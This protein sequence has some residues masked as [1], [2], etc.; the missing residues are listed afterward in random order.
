MFCGLCA[1][2]GLC[3]MPFI[4]GLQEF[5]G[6]TVYQK[7]AT[8]RWQWALPVTANIPSFV[9]LA[10][11][12][13]EIWIIFSYFWSS[14]DRVQSTNRKRYIWAH[15][16]ICT[17]GLINVRHKGM[18]LR[19]FSVAWLTSIHPTVKE[20]LQRHLSWMVM[21]LTLELVIS[22]GFF[23]IPQHGKIV[24][25]PPGRSRTQDSTMSL[26]VNLMLLLVYWIWSIT[27]N[28]K[29]S[30]I[31]KLLHGMVSFQYKPW[32][33]MCYPKYPLTITTGCWCYSQLARNSN[34]GFQ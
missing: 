34:W 6:L 29:W 21:G 3:L 22:L 2:C 15:H 14:T 13:L 25:V 4:T 7:N 27:Q 9:L 30:P 24:G 28:K 26:L 5:L 10:T 18:T 23:D 8:W 19:Y 11:T 31:L 1:F 20:T 12:L 33:K 32:C 17:G 16:A